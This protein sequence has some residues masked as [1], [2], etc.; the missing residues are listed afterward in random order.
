MGDCRDAVLTSRYLEFGRH[1]PEVER[2]NYRHCEQA[3]GEYRCG[4]QGSDQSGHAY[5][6][7]RSGERDHQELSEA[8][9]A[10]IVDYVQ[11]VLNDLPTRLTVTSIWL[12]RALSVADN[13]VSLSRI[14][15]I[16][17]V[18]EVIQRV[19]RRIR[20]MSANVP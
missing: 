7:H 16:T 11:I 4:S 18:S 2:E 13:T 20:I 8:E 1:P 17:V 3:G 9:S 5:R 19:H 6:D 15:R 14:I 12:K 10:H